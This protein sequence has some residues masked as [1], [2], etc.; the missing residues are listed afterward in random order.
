MLQDLLRTVPLFAELDPSELREVVLLFRKCSF[1]SSERLLVEGLHGDYLLVIE[2]GRI[3][4]HRH[5]EDG[6]EIDLAVLERGALLGDMALIDAAPR[7][8]GATAREP[9]IAHRFN[10]S[11]FMKLV[12]A[13]SPAAL[14]IL[15]R[16][17]VSTAGRLREVNRRIPH[18]WSADKD[19]A[20]PLATSGRDIEVVATLSR[21]PFFK[22]F[23]AAELR[24]LQGRV[25]ERHLSK[26][27]VLI[28]SKEAGESL[29]FVLDGRFCVVLPEGTEL[30][31][32]SHGSLVGHFSFLDAKPRSA[33]VRATRSCCVLEF[34]RSDY[35]SMFA[36]RTTA[37]FKFTEALARLVTRQLREANSRVFGDAQ[38]VVES[39][40]GKLMERM[41][42]RAAERRAQLAEE[43]SLSSGAGNSLASGNVYLRK[44]PQQS[45]ATEE[46]L[47][48]L[49]V[50]AGSFGANT[51]LSD[52]AILRLRRAGSSTFDAGPGAS[53]IR[54]GLLSGASGIR[55][56][57]L[58]GASGV[59]AGL[60]P[61]AS[62][63]RPSPNQEP[64]T[65]ALRRLKKRNAANALESPTSGKFKPKKRDDE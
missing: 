21:M 14:K 44:R 40:R 29:F 31:Y 2:S 56:G 26:D 43:A 38:G 39:D 18:D 28:R 47:K 25:I 48:R 32:V 64:S 3:Q 33:T 20:A 60:A 22:A 49:Q 7:S 17:A 11:D 13:K 30:G 58:S 19:E 45:G 5:G 42:K 52:D 35:D 9:V 16:I 51:T 55:P 37:A 12:M 4:I 36:R 63:V 62:G 24:E 27:E 41:M 34:R 1:R 65:P 8:A 6:K 50:G 61:G 46:E 59:R 15:R 54:P 10:R 57:L 23:T 53:S